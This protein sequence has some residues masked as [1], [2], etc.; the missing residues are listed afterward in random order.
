MFKKLIWNS[1][2]T[3]KDCGDFWEQQAAAFLA[4]QGASCLARNFSSRFGEIDLIV[5]DN[6]FI[7]FVE[8]KYRQSTTYGGAINAI[9]KQKQQRI[10]K[11]ATFYLQKMKLNAYNT[12]CRFDVVAIQGTKESPQIT[13]LKDAFN[14]VQ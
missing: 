9:P 6:E 7:A 11:T 14:G 2:S 13:W 8:V 3:T 4:N 5:Q 12:A 10:V 1:Q